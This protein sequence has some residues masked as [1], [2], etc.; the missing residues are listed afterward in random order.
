MEQKLT[1]VIVGLCVA[2]GILVGGNLARY[3]ATQPIRLEMP[4]TTYLLVTAEERE[5][6][7]M[8]YEEEIIKY[9]TG[10]YIITSC[11]EGDL[12]L[13]FTTGHYLN[14]E[15]QRMTL[16]S[17]EPIPASRLHLWTFP[18]PYPIDGFNE[19]FERWLGDSQGNIAQ[20]LKEKDAN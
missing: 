12:C 18:N 3:E 15:L 20:Y 10:D 6:L 17:R 14:G 5:Y 4:Q 19:A 2:A 1:L 7:K 9:I 16:E 13:D 8:A 11:L